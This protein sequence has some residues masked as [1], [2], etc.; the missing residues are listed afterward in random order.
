MRDVGRR[1]AAAEAATRIRPLVTTTAE[2]EL[3]MN[4]MT[5]VIPKD[6]SAQGSV[7]QMLKERRTGTSDELESSG[8][9]YYNETAKRRFD[10]YA[11]QEPDIT[12]HLY[13]VAAEVNDVIGP[14]DLEPRDGA[15]RMDAFK[16]STQRPRQYPPKGTDI[17]DIENISLV[18]PPKV[19]P[20]EASINLHNPRPKSCNKDPTTRPRLITTFA[21]AHPL[22]ESNPTSILGTPPKAA[23]TTHKSVY[24]VSEVTTDINLELE[25]AKLKLSPDTL[26]SMSSPTTTPTMTSLKTWSKRCKKVVEPPNPHKPTQLKIP[27]RSAHYFRPYVMRYINNPSLEHTIPGGVV[28][29]LR[30]APHRHKTILET[31]KFINPDFGTEKDPFKLGRSKILIKPNISTTNRR[32]STAPEA[33]GAT[34]GTKGGKLSR[35]GSRSAPST[36]RRESMSAR[37]RRTSMSV[38]DSVRDTDE[39]LWRK[40]E[41]QW[42]RSMPALGE[43]KVMIRRGSIVGWSGVQPE[44]RKRGVGG[45]ILNLAGR[46]GSVLG[47]GRVGSVRD[48]GGRVGSFSGLARKAVEAS[49]IEDGFGGEDE[50]DEGMGRLKK[51]GYKSTVRIASP[52][53]SQSQRDRQTRSLWDADSRSQTLIP[54]PSSPFLPTTPSVRP[55]STKSSIIKSQRPKSSIPPPT[56]EGLIDKVVKTVM[57]KRKEQTRVKKLGQSRNEFRV[58]PKAASLGD[59][60]EAEIMALST[61]VWAVRE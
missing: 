18:N 17:D 42:G 47:G 41:A 1:V 19:P 6:P 31:I 44:R 15:G 30:D 48:L 28:K 39:G 55:Q 27:A 52:L 29:L 33:D 32:P 60:K 45:S 25:Q 54:S 16:V 40:Y 51:G 56:T 61:S 20:A 10:I 26:L 59:R 11:R 38:E 4:R 9:A 7:L 58:I 43:E 49:I 53:P 12:R 37:H 34:T 23:H 3:E 57:E 22:E 21:W 46:S 8:P 13:S 24:K 36:G 2:R 35:R 50:P 5:G 14:A